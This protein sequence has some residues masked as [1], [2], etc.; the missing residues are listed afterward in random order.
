MGLEGDVIGPDPKT[1]K[2]YIYDAMA[3]LDSMHWEREVLDGDVDSVVEQ[4]GRVDKWSE[5][6]LSEAGRN[7]HVGYFL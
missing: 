5:P 7:R 3:D 4:Y 1:G 2:Y 6:E